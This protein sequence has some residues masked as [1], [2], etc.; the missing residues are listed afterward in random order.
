MVQ[1]Q[2]YLPGPL[3][4][5]GESAQEKGIFNAVGEDKSCEN[6]ND[7]CHGKRC[8]WVKN[9]LEKKMSQ[10]RLKLMEWKAR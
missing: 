1:K 2:F 6:V 8:W 5:V 10:L 7:E 3:H 9:M 4:V